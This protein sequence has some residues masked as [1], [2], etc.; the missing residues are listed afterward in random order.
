MCAGATARMLSKLAD[1]P[2]IICAD[3]SPGPS[4]LRDTEVRRLWRAVRTKM[5]GADKS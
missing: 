4:D 1:A 2:M 5:R 3:G